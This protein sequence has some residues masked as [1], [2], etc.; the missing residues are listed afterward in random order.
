MSVEVENVES[1]DEIL[2]SP[3]KRKESDRIYLT[4]PKRK[5]IFDNLDFNIKTYD[6]SSSINSF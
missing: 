4:H 2:D 3:D 5:E 6:D 1:I